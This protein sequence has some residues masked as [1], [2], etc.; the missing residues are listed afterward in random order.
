MANGKDFFIELRK[1]VSLLQQGGTVLGV[2][3]LLA[4]WMLR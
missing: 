4:G 3:A 1:Q 2:E